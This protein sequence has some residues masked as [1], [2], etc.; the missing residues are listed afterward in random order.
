MIEEEARELWSKYTSGLALSSAETAALI[1]AMET[2]ETLRREILE[3]AKLH[4]LL[5]A[6]QRT[7][8]DADAFERAFLQL[9]RGQKDATRF[10]QR[11]ESQVGES[12]R[13]EPS[14]GSPKTSRRGIRE[15]GTRRTLQRPSEHARSSWMG[16]A[17]AAA[18]ILILVTLIS[19]LTSS[20][21]DPAAV[22]R[23]A[24]VR[25]RA[26]R[27]AEARRQA[28]P[29]K[30]QREHTLAEAKK[31]R[32]ASEAQLREIEAQ[33]RLLIQAKPETAEDP[34]AKNK[35]EK[36]LEVL[37]RD[38]ERVERELRKAALLAQKPERPGPQE[39][40]R[41]ENPQP[42]PTEK[43]VSPQAPTQ[44]ALAR[45]EEI[46]GEAYRVT[47]D[48]KTPLVAGTDVFPAEGLQTGGDA[49]RIVLR[50][51]DKTRVDLGPAT[52]VTEMKIERGKRLAL[53]QGTLRAV[54]AKQ[55]VDQPMIIETPHGKSTVLGT[56]LRIVI[57]PDPAKGT[58]LE[59]E[60]GK[61][62]LGNLAGRTVSVESGH[63]AVAADGVGLVAKPISFWDGALAVYRFNEGEGTKVRDLSRKGSPLDLKIENLSCVQ[64]LPT[65]LAIVAPTVIASSSPAR[66]IIEAS[67]ATNEL[68]LE[69]W[70]R[71]LTL[72]QARGDAR[73][74]TLS[75]DPGNQNFLLGQDGAGGPPNSFVVRFRTTATDSIGK[76]QM[77]SP[78]G[79]T[80][81]R[82]TQVVYCRSRSGAAFLYL[83][84]QEVALA[85]TPG[86]LSTWNDGYRLA[87]GNE[88]VEGRP[89]LGEY[90]LVALYS[91]VLSPEEI[92]QHYRA[93][94][95]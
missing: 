68:T 86:N 61:V 55:P 90:Q 57:D 89:W 35:R 75:A 24:G 49:S 29:E 32:L 76:P 3:D 62:E 23:A 88:F 43:G 6:F 7:S 19:V 38:Q 50:F 22:E 9:Q 79:R 92:K 44:V 26:S 70:I 93:G 77:D 45:V 80:A 74:V 85:S 12:T 54:V 48:G 51:P 69:A 4:G 58:R 18:G 27:E 36:E 11:V 13:S 1:S 31:K 10:L 73:I 81:L 41:D 15:Q 72:T 82:K 78:A 20:E 8:R 59:V 63:Y 37:K 56:T 94:T 60:E 40:T 2:H 33:Q 30:E 34:Q 91:R 83:D 5:R 65:G 17:I 42:K 71:P 67:K 21:P 16:W 47:K 14:R 64:W 39:Q 25:A 52:S 84:G 66:K 46:F 95:E 28:D 87:L 53:T